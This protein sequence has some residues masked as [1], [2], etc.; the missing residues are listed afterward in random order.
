[1]Q[2]NGIDVEQIRPLDDTGSSAGQQTESAKP[3]TSEGQDDVEGETALG[4]PNGTRQTPVGGNEMTEAPVT[5]QLTPS[6]ENGAESAAKFKSM[7]QKS[8]VEKVHFIVPADDHDV[9]HRENGV[10]ENSVGV[11]GT[12]ADGDVVMGS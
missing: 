4:T 3:E 5:E 11:N 12:D 7:T 2:S 10:G 9:S 6:K 8:L 1:M